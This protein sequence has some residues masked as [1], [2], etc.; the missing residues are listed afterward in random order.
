MME[1]S[2]IIEWTG[3]RPKIATLIDHTPNTPF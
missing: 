3:G 1:D 2:R